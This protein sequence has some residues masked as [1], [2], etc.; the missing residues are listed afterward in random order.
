MITYT[1]LNVSFILVIIVL[2]RIKPRRPS[3][4][5]WRTLIAILLLTAV[6]DSIIVGLGIVAYDTEKILG[7]TIGNA[8]VEDFFYALLA[9]VIVPVIW[10]GLN[11]SSG[12]KIK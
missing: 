8:P 12:R 5:W 6:F 2:L 10:K 3:R 4:A 1:I 7:V 11:K 9:C